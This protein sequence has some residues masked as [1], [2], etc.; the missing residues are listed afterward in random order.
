MH[1]I[2]TTE[3]LIIKKGKERLSLHNLN[4]KMYMYIFY[5]ILAYSMHGIK[6]LIVYFYVLFKG[7]YYLLCMFVY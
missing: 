7:H 4:K 2:I 6:M 1:F 5:A 3:D